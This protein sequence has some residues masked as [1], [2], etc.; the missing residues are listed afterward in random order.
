MKKVVRSKPFADKGVKHV[1][2]KHLVPLVYQPEHL[3]FR[4][5]ET[6]CRTAR[7]TELTDGVRPMVVKGPF[8]LVCV[9]KTDG[10]HDYYLRNHELN[11]MVP[12]GY[13]MTGSIDVDRKDGDKPSSWAGNTTTVN[14]NNLRYRV[15][16]EFE[17]VVVVDV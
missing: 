5:P 2:K 13:L 10:G 15:T 16:L 14:P 8:E 11:I 9:R 4:C 6:G 7:R 12:I 1:C 3:E 17:G